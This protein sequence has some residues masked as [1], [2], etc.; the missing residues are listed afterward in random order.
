MERQVDFI[1][2]GQAKQIFDYFT[3][4]FGIRMVFFSYDGT[5]LISGDDR[6]RCQFCS[7][8]RSQLGY[9]F[10]CR[11]LDRKMQ[12]QAAS[13]KELTRYTCHAGMVEAVMPVFTVDRLIGYI[14]IGQF[15]T[16]DSLKNSIR[17]HWQ[18]MFK[19][20]E[21]NNVFLQS[22]CYD[23]ERINDITGLF[24]ILVKTI[25][26]HH[27]V[28]VYSDIS[29]Q[30]II[31]YIDEYPQS[32]ITIT[33]AA[34]MLNCSRSTLTHS[35]KK[36]TGQSFKKYLINRK[37]KYAD[38]LLKS[39]KDMKINEIANSIGYEDPYLFSRV[40]KKH[41]LQSPSDFRKNY[42]PNVNRNMF[43]E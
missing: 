38:E 22:P 21:L 31:S 42:E 11:H 37:L 2:Q 10:R 36:A 8:L 20:D 5:E 17:R 9:E 26:S 19:N 28:M 6:P 15:R 35:F 27:L 24:S 25:I 41:R 29:I 4:L 39:R 14:M 3:R 18:L 30:K 23:E 33:E 13:V 16:S 43:S 12:L 1:F 7:M 34:N 40:Y 32:N